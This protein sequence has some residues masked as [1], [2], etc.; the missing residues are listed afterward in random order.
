M[1]NP[2]LDWDAILPKDLGLV[3]RNRWTELSTRYGLPFSRKTMQ[4]L[5]SKGR[6]PAAVMV[7]GKVAYS[8]AALV[9]FLNNLPIEKLHKQRTKGEH[10]RRYGK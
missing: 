4:N 7:A 9:A 6:G 10:T 2:A 1:E 5:D 3:F 8:R